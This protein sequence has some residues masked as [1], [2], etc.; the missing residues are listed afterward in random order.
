MDIA[1]W[2]F[3]AYANLLELSGLLSCTY[4]IHHWEF[5]CLVDRVDFVFQ[6]NSDTSIFK[7]TGDRDPGYGS[8]S[9]MLAES[10]ICLAKDNLDNKFGVLTPSYAMGDHIL[11][12]LISKAGLSF[13][14]IK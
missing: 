13:S 4:Q 2:I 3:E 7:V 6:E 8:T 12:R 10:A 5:E 9:K 14:K 11:D 1:T